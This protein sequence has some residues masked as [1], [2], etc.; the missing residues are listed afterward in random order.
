MKLLLNCDIFGLQYQFLRDGNIKK[1]TKIGVLLTIIYLIIVIALFFGFGIDLYTRKNPKVSF[2]SVIK[3]YEEKNLTNNQFFFAYRIENIN[4]IQVMDDSIINLNLMNFKYEMVDG[5]WQ[6][7]KANWDLPNTRCSNILNISEKER[8]YNISLKNWFCIDFNNQTMGGNWDG[9]FVNFNK[10]TKKYS[11]FVNFF[12]IAVRQ[13]VNST[14]NNNTCQSQDNILKSFRSDTA[15]NYLFSYLYMEAMPNLDDFNEPIKSTLINRY[16]MLDTKIIK[17]HVH[18]FKQTNVNDDRGWIFSD[19][20]L[21]FIYA[22]DNLLTDFTLKDENKE[23]LVFGYFMYFGKRYE[24]YNRT[25]MKVQEVIASIG[26][27]SKFFHLFV[28]LL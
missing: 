24:V 3:S 20:D 26:G 8:Y 21:K 25:Y 28:S 1:K 16:E 4:G 14:A 11:F 10:I 17:K 23:S 22:S 18:T 9:D 7:V 12:T 13:C 19:V 15:A 6:I 5:E 2:N 27:F